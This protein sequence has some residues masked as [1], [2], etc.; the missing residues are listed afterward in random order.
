SLRVV[1]EEKAKEKKAREAIEAG[2]APEEDDSD[3][4]TDDDGVTLD[5]QIEFCRDLLSQ[6]ATSTNRQ[7]QLRQAKPFVDQRRAMEQEKVRKAL[8]AMGLNWAKAPA[9]PQQGSQV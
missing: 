2:Q 1:K 5:Y 9:A 8:E 4:P 6:A 7:E 3:D